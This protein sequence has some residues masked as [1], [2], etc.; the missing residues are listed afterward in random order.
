MS[1]YMCIH[2]MCIYT[3][4]CICVYVCMCICVY[5]YMCI[6]VY[7]YMCICVPP[8]YLWYYLLSTLLLV[9]PLGIADDIIKYYCAAAAAA[10]TAAAAAAVDFRNFFVFFW[11][12][13]LAHW[14]PTS[15]QKKHPQLVCSDLRLSDRKF[16]DWNYGN[17]PCRR[18]LCSNGSSHS[19][20]K[21]NDS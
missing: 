3:H 11:A 9:V 16:E 18:D 1:M 17:R 7:V 8:L 20:G 12:E 19:D 2:V 5:V 21:H 15:C 14:N 13:T 6:C 4:M 10:A